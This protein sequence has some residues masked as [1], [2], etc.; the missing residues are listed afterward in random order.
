MP[1]R[2]DE[3]VV[4]VLSVRHDSDASYLERLGGGPEPSWTGEP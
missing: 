1:I 3:K 4:A 2:A